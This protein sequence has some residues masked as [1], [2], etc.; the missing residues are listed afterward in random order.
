MNTVA[1]QGGVDAWFAPAATIAIGATLVSLAT[2]LLLHVMSPEFAPS[3]RM[4]SEYANGRYPWLLTLMFI[5][6]AVTSFALIAALWPLSTT[7]LGR[8]GLV[9]LALAGVGQ[10]MGALFDIN[11]KL[12]GPAAMIGIPSLCIAAV[13]VT[14]A[15]S[16]RADVAAP[17]VWSAHLP[18]ISFALM[19]GALAMFVSALKSAGM[20]MTAQATPLSQLPEGV[21]GYVGWANRLLFA[22]TYLWAALAALSVLRARA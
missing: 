1:N 15:L 3:W 19:L 7:T 11:H 14:M 8:V 12:H 4:V 17:P 13:L 22:S 9:F 16:R 20:D 2:L 5:G 18:W 10:T 21:S 6:W